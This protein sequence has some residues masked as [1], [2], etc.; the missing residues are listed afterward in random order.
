MVKLG[1]FG[2]AKTLSTSGELAKTVVGTPYYMSPELSQNKPYG[3][4]SD[5]WALGCLLYEMCTFRHP[6]EAQNYQ[7]LIGRIA[8]GYYTKLPASKFSRELSSL[9]DSMLNQRPERRP[10]TA[11]IL[12]LPF[13]RARMQ[14]LLNE[15]ATISPPVGKALGEGVK[16]KEKVKAEKGKS[17]AEEG[18]EKKSG[19]E[20]IALLKE[21]LPRSSPSYQNPTSAKPDSHKGTSDSKGTKSLS[22]SPSVPV[23]S[24]LPGARYPSSGKLSSRT[25]RSQSPRPLSARP[26]APLTKRSTSSSSSPSS[27]SSASSASSNP[28]HSNRP[29]SQ[30]KKPY[31]ADYVSPYARPVSARRLSPAPPHLSAS[32]SAHNTS[33][34]SSPRPS[35]PR[36]SSAHRTA[37]ES[38]HEAHDI[39]SRPSSGHP[40][41]VSRHS[42]PSLAAKPPH[43]KPTSSPS[44]SALPSPAHSPSPSPYNSPNSSYSSRPSSAHRRSNSYQKIF[45]EEQQNANRLVSS[46]S[47]STSYASIQHR[48]SSSALPPQPPQHSSSASSHSPDHSASSTTSSSSATSSSSSSTSSA[49]ADESLQK[50]K[51]V[52]STHSTTSAIK[53]EENTSASDDRQPPSF[54]TSPIMHTSAPHP[55]ES[56]SVHSD[57]SEKDAKE[58]K[59]A[60]NLQLFERKAA[61]LREITSELQNPRAKLLQK[62]EERSRLERQRDGSHTNIPSLIP[63]SLHNEDSKSSSDTSLEAQPVKRAHQPVIG[64]PSS[65]HTPSSG[66]SSKHPLTPPPVLHS[67][68][69]E[70]SD[71]EGIKA[72]KAAPATSA[73][74]VL[75]LD[76]AASPEQST[77]VAAEVTL[78]LVIDANDILDETPDP[79][80]KVEKSIEE[81]KHFHDALN[82]YASV[83]K[84]PLSEEQPEDDNDET[85]DDFGG[86][87][88]LDLE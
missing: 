20:A 79:Q 41:L 47:H 54:V 21:L 56:S 51:H 76:L 8:K 49:P 43:H 30:P 28:T 18:K 75:S 7:Q 1:D 32:P 4:K 63:D 12:D 87:E 44:T 55:T 81:R 59:K 62:M 61:E 22:P 64:Q 88:D 6:F 53:V 65:H 46:P 9:V 67:D 26:N 15:S 31:G 70:L 23:I 60:Q 14:A 86:E 85:F 27:P 74:S 5:V 13:I 10:T 45:R 38:A 80:E 39:H 17:E 34:P 37:H 29:L 66:S 36:P 19:A 83:L 33:R 82:E 84:K 35:D 3:Y 69:D 2:I 73:S 25:P 40:P 68:Q 58:L 72:V 57:K 52:P 71:H 11:Q 78:Q 48:R 50:Q 42:S 24:L 16:E 77:R